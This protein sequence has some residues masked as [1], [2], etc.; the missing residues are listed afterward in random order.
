MNRRDLAYEHGISTL[1]KYFDLWRC[2]YRSFL[3][4]GHINGSQCQLYM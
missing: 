4:D 1:P 2:C 3:L